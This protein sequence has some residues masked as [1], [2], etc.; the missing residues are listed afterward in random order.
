MTKG[1]ISPLRQRMIEDMTS[2]K[3]CAGTQKRHIRGCRR[4]ADFLKRSPETSEDV[5]RHA[6]IETIF[7]P[8]CLGR[9][10]RLG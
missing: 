6:N 2:R 5:Q 7:F 9:N 10:I 8:K 4:F 1:S 3:L